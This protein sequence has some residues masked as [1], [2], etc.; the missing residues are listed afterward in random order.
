MLVFLLKITGIPPTEIRAL[1][2]RGERYREYQRTTSAFF[3]WFPEGGEVM[4][5]PGLATTLGLVERGLVPD[6]GHAAE[7]GR[8]S[9]AACAS[10]NA[11][12]RRPPGAVPGSCSRTCGPGRSRCTPMRSQRAALRSAGRVLRAGLGPHRKYSG[13]YWPPGVST[14]DRG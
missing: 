9:A 3:P 4:S 6:D 7:F 11:Q 14:L 5:L 13:C 12:R 10:A 8:W 1:Q 2:S